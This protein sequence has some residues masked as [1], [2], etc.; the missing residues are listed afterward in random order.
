MEVSFTAIA[1]EKRCGSE[2]MHDAVKALTAEERASSTSSADGIS[3]LSRP[4]GGASP[5]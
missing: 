1:A 2:Q 5:P 4:A 3:R